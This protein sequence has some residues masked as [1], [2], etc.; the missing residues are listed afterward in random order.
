MSVMNRVL[1]NHSELH[2]R[3]IAV[4]IVPA[5]MGRR[6]EVLDSEAEA[7]LREKRHARNE[8]DAARARISNAYRKGHQAEAEK[9]VWRAHR[10]ATDDGKSDEVIELFSDS[11][12]EAGFVSGALP[13]RHIS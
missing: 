10:T 2:L 1:E 5:A 13:E 6:E 12:S 8:R 7:A 9:T 4:P 11:E 3:E